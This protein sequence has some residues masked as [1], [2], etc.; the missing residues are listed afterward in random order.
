MGRAW[1]LARALPTPPNL[2]PPPLLL[3]S[4]L[5]LPLTL[6]P[7]SRD[8]DTH[9]G[10]CVSSSTERLCLVVIPS[11]GVSPPFS[12]SGLPS[13]RCWPPTGAVLGLRA[14]SGLAKAGVRVQGT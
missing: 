13:D 14:I 10:C 12:W 3:P 5:R 11:L 8:C 2:P 1:N 6:R 4:S 7:P 9:V